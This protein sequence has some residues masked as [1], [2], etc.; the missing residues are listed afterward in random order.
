ME[1]FGFEALSP[2][3]YPGRWN[4]DEKQFIFGTVIGSM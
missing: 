3:F 1:R 2:H 4:D